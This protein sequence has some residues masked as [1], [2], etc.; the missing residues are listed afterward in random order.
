MEFEGYRDKVLSRLEAIDDIPSLPMVISRLTAAIQDVDSSASDVARIMEDDPSIMAR[1]LKIVNSSFYSSSVSKQDI[2][3][4]R[5]AIVRLGYDAVRNIA[6]TSSVFSIFKDD[7]IKVFNRTE[8]WRHCISTGIIAN[9]VC[10]YSKHNEDEIPRESVALAGL[11]HDMGKIIFEQYFY[12]MF[13][14]ILNYAAKNDQALYEVEEKVFK[15]THSEIGAWLARRWKLS[16]DLIACIEFHHCPEK[17][18]KAL[19][20]MVGLVHVADYICNLKKIGQSGNPRPPQFR[21]DVWTGLGLNIEKINEIVARAD[22]EA[23]K[24]EIL[25]SLS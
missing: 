19:Q 12:D 9:V 13:T 21:E 10:Q 22:E 3:N 6:L 1:V 24:S 16:E 23:Q 4:V 15:I 18:P 8:F 7:H 17:A 14:N 11:L 5:H 25:L 2:T 20:P